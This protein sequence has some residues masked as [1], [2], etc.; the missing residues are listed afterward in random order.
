[1]LLPIIFP[2]AISGFLSADAKTLTTSSG[3]EVPNATIVSPI[4][5]FGIFNFFAREDALSIS[6][7]APRINGTKPAMSKL[8][9]N[10]FL[11]PNL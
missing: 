9:N 4:T 11:Y 3:A 1:M 10:I 8:K 6:K 5:M 2:R 7:F